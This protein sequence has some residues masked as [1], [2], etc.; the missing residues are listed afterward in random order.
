MVRLNE[1]EHKDVV[2][3]K[4]KLEKDILD[5]LKNHTTLATEKK[6]LEDNFKQKLKDKQDETTAKIKK[7]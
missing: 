5:A 7:R 2:A 1:K 6:I 4:E 3:A